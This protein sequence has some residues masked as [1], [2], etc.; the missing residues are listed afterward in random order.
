MAAGFSKN[1]H[2]SDA[3]T[4]EGHYAREAGRNVVHPRSRWSRSQEDNK[5]G[6]SFATFPG[7]GV[8]MVRNNMRI[9]KGD[10]LFRVT[11]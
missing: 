7:I 3:I 8:I 1:F 4:R 10:P 2:E 11:K 6:S 5:D 9:N